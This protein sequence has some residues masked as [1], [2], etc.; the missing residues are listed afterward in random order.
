MDKHMHK[1]QRR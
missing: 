1:G